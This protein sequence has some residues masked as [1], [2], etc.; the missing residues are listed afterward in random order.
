MNS[1]SAPSQSTEQINEQ[2]INTESNIN[3][4]NNEN[5]SQENLNIEQYQNE[6]LSP[7]KLKFLIEKF[8]SKAYERSYIVKCL[9]KD[10]EDYQLYIQS[11]LEAKREKIN[12]IITQLQSVVNE[13]DSNYTVRLYGSYSTGLCLP[14]SDIDTVIESNDGKYDPNFLNKLNGKLAHKDWVKEQNYIDRATIPIIKLISKDEYNFHIDISMSSEN[15]FGL[16]TVT[17]VNEYLRE[18]KVLKPIIL[19]LKTLLKNGN[20]NDPY[21]GGLSS[22]GLILMVVSFMTVGKKRE[23]NYDNRIEQSKEEIMKLKGKNNEISG[24]WNLIKE[25]Q[26][27]FGE[28]EA[29]ELIEKSHEIEDDEKIKCKKIIEEIKKSLNKIIELKNAQQMNSINF[30]KKLRKAIVRPKDLC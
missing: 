11:E 15:H 18:Y 5:H 25:L 13:I 4:E 2:E 29:N 6:P 28:D 27:K 1:E 3:N 10:L 21:K 24:K 12:D 19:A 14:W 9:Q 17:L 30:Y 20:L 7:E 23:K 26:E 22:Y 16:K 8:D